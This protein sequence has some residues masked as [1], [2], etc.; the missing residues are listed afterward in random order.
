MWDIT[1][2]EDEDG[3]EKEVNI[4]FL[5]WKVRTPHLPNSMCLGALE[6]AYVT[7]AFGKC[8]YHHRVKVLMYT[9]AFDKCVDQMH[10]LHLIRCT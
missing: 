7:F 5:H 4:I 2:E 10:L 8:V 3:E 6:G 9:F 1:E